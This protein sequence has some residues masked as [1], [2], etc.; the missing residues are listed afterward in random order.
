MALTDSPRVRDAVKTLRHTRFGRNVLVLSGGTAAGQA[1]S[2]L[3]AP[4]ITRLYS[5]A[6]YGVLGV[7]MSALALTSVMAMLRYE[8]AITVSD[9]DAEGMNVL[10]LALALALGTSLIGVIC[11]LFYAKLYPAH[12]GIQ[13]FAHYAWFL[14]FGMFAMAAYQAL[15]FWSIRKQD[16]HT[17]AQT[18]INQS[19]GMIVVQIAL[20]VCRIGPLGLLIGH[21]VGQSGGIGTLSRRIVRRDRP[22][23]AD[24]SLE[25]MRTAG[26]R[27]RR[28]PQYSL[29]AAFLDTSVSNL[30]IMMIASL[31]GIT[32]AGWY[33]LVQRGLFMPVSLMTSSVSQVYVGEMA[34]LR[35]T[36]AAAMRQTFIRRVRQMVV[37]SMGST[38]LLMLIAV[39]FVPLVFGAAWAKA[40]TIALIL[41]PMLLVSMAAGPFGCTLDV[42]QRQDLHLLRDSVRFA[43]IVC[44]FAVIY[45]F[46]LNWETTMCLLSAAGALSYLFY[47]WI[48]WHAVS[49]YVVHHAVSSPANT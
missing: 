41:S 34:H 6:E 28:F 26:Y 17:L 12:T 32:V 40:S 33:T 36:D 30:P 39:L 15:L 7:Y 16:F 23:L 45:W 8:N 2:V 37:V 5:P 11:V 21:V 38:I 9:S 47:L 13:S 1:L 24:I 18:K 3:A 44:A 46:R 48:S 49:T 25:R 14:P 35:R 19:I 22:A 10:A 4:I 27:H 20:G 29:L 42:T 43:L 31:F